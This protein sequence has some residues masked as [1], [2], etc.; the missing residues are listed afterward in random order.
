MEKMRASG[1]TL[2]ELLI[3]LSILGLIATFAIPKVLQA[4]RNQAWN[5]SAKEAI[6]TISEA[7][8]L[9]LRK[10]GPNANMDPYALIPY[11]NYGRIDNTATLDNAPG[12]GTWECSWGHCLVL[13][14]GGYLYVNQGWITFGQPNANNFV[15]FMFDPDGKQTGDSAATGSIVIDLFYNGKVITGMEENNTHVT[16]NGGAPVTGTTWPKPDWFNW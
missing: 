6:A 9:Y 13:H 5:A 16:Y 14:G 10:N 15:Q 2:S 1:F 12:W 3:S 4:Q 8:Q 11:M 7:Y